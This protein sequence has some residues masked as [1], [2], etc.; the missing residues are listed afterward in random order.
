MFIQVIQGRTKDAEGFKRQVERWGQEVKPGAK[1]FLGSTG[2]VAA[3]GTTIALVRFED[4]ASAV[5]NSQR[6][7]QTA[8]WNE[9]AKYFDG[10]PT[11][12]ESSD[13]EVNV[14]RGADP[15]TLDSAGFVQVMQ[16]SVADRAKVVAMEKQFMPE[17]EKVRPDVMGSVRSWDGNR[18]TE[19]IYFT[20]EAA[21]REG[22]K[23]ME[24][25]GGDPEA[26]AGMAEF[27]AL[28]DVGMTYIDLTDP[29][30]QSP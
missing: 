7:E 9:T 15:S 10:D 25:G 19:A 14:N 11:F 30:F 28:F 12:R 16:G 27:M 6:P 21:A 20:S 2:G 22:E 5:A 13:V 26:A 29:W 17:M 8:W 3:D 18:F 4:E 1:G 24:D 23:A